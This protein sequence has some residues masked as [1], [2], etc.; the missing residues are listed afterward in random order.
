MKKL[1]QRR[2]NTQAGF[3]LI[4]LVVV[5][6]ILGILAVTAAPKFIDLQGDARKAVREGVVASVQSAL[7]LGHAKALVGG[8]TGATGEILV[9]GQYVST[10][11]GYPS[12]IAVSSKDGTSGNGYNI[13]ELLNIQGGD[14]TV[15]ANTAVANPLT[16]TIATDCTVT[17]TNAVAVNTTP[18]VAGIATC[19]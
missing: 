17:L 13:I 16:I 10:V 11:F 9:S 19:A 12:T 3:T 4:E 6:V 1:T 7:S 18:T 2:M 15:P 8:E 5:I 14:V